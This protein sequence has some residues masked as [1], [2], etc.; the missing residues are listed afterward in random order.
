MKQQK[1]VTIGKKIEHKYT[2][3]KN[4]GNIRDQCHNTG[5]YRGAVH[6]NCSI[7]KEILQ[8]FTMHKTMVIIFYHKRA[9]K[10]V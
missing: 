6:G 9:S 4:Y 5:K 8:F 7:P 1:S 2:N 10:S 3:D